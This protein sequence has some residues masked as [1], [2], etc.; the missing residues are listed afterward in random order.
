MN[1]NYGDS[2]EV[3]SSLYQLFY[4]VNEFNLHHVTQDYEVLDLL[5]K[6]GFATVFRAK[7]KRNHQEVAIKKV[8]TKILDLHTPRPGNDIHN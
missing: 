4:L 5:G 8:R 7:S 2:I 3:C 1:P 6:G